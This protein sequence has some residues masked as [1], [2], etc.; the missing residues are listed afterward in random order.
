MGDTYVTW[1]LQSDKQELVAGVK[2]FGNKREKGSQNGSL[3][4]LT[5]FFD[6]EDRRLCAMHE[7]MLYRGRW[8]YPGCQITSPPV[9]RYVHQLDHNIEWLN[10]R[11]VAC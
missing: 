4:G 5:G 2:D 1:H 6:A 9:C 3:E 8:F 7:Q 10:L 11:N